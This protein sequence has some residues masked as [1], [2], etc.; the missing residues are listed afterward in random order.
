MRRPWVR[1]CLLVRGPVWLEQNK[2]GAEG[3]VVKS[4]S[5]GARG[6]TYQIV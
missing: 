4:D 3:K 2:R 1:M 6:N 5:Y